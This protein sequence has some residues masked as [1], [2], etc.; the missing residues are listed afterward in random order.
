[1]QVIGGCVQCPDGV[2]LVPAIGQN[3]W[4]EPWARKEFAMSDDSTD[5]R[6]FA[7]EV[8][9]RLRAAGHEALWAGGCVRDRLLGVEPKDYDVA[10]NATPDEIRGVFGHRRTLAIGAAFGVITVLGGRHAGQIEVATFRKD[11]KYSDGRHPD[12]VSFSSAEEDAQRR[13]FTI[14]G[15]FYDPLADKVIDYVGGQQDLKSGIVRAIGDPSARIAEDK[16]RMLRAVRF[17]ATLDFQLDPSTRS[18]V[19]ANAA[20]I[21]VVSAERVAA[22]MRRMLVHESR[23]VAVELL[24]ETGLLREIL[25][26]AKLFDSQADDALWTRTLRTLMLLESP[27]FPVALA[28]LIREICQRLAES[29]TRPRAAIVRQICQRWRLSNDETDCTIWLLVRESDIRR[30]SQIPWPRL[31]PI[32]V[33][34]QINDL[35]QLAAA[36]ARIVDGNDQEIR[37]CQAK[38]RLPPDELDPWP[39]VGGEDLK[40]AGIPPGRVYSRLLSELRDAQLEKRI[41]SKVEAIELARSIWSS[42][43]KP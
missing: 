14:N 27:R 23:T 32:L 25:P 13:D 12:S 2:V 3:T 6:Q 9:R 5:A 42:S 34:S 4:N 24:R 38:L 19:K 26:D 39:L 15:L 43:R 1:M 10:T 22:E 35:M 21:Q 31:Q 28:A 8:V 29:E 17:A 7:G 33:S 18:A 37:F 30:A 16:L 41:G 40:A 36:V 11:A 20:E